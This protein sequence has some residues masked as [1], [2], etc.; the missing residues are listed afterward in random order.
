[1]NTIKIHLTDDRTTYT[2]EQTIRGKLEWQLDD[3]PRAIELQLI[4]QTEG[5]GT[6]D[7][8]AAVVQRWDSPAPSDELSFELTVPPGPLS[9]H[10]S[11]I[12]ILWTLEA[13]AVKPHA[14]AS[15]G[16]TISTAGQAIEFSTADRDE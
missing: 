16:I 12:S 1:M 5:K 8:D 10:G 15:C 9:Y 11:M 13:L 3:R 14:V 7:A 4:W 2:P 6:K